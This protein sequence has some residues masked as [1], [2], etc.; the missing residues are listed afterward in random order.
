[1]GQTPNVVFTGAAV[2]TDDG[3]LNVYYGGADTSMCV[4]QTTVDDLVAFCLCSG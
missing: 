1:M 4:A 2:A 3:K